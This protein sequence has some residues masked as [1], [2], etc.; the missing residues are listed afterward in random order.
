MNTLAIAFHGEGPTDWR[1]FEPLTKNLVAQ[2]LLE[3]AEEE[4]EVL[5]LNEFQAEGDSYFQK[6]VSLCDQLEG[7]HMLILHRDGTPS[8]QKVMENHFDRVL[9]DEQLTNRGLWLVPLIPVRETEAWMLADPEWLTEELKLLG[10]RPDELDLPKPQEIESI[11]DPKLRLKEIMQKATAHRTSRQRRRMADI[12]SLYESAGN[13]VRIEVLKALP[14]FQ[15]FEHYL[16]QALQRI[17]RHRD[18]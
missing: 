12:S 3:L 1:F 8:L 4:W 2:L 5:V 16:R 18:G 13:L 10:A 15:T 11:A 7:Y 17:I 14:S 6:V 9:R